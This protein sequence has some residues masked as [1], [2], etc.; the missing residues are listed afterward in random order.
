MKTNKIENFIWI[1][2]LVIGLI[3]LIVGIIICINTFDY[4]DKIETTGVITEITSYRNRDGDTIHNVYVKYEING[5]QYESKL[6]SYSSNFYEGKE[7]KIYY[8][9]DNIGNIGVKSLDLMSLMFPGFGIIFSSIG[10]IS[11]FVQL[12][13]KKLEKLLKESGTRINAYYVETVINTSYSVNNNHPYNIICEW[14]NPMDNKKYIFKSENIWVNPE[15]II[16]ERNITT[17]PVYIDMNNKK[18]YVVDI[19]ELEDNVVDLR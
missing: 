1:S 7:I 15:S 4:T 3:F 17:F 9:K 5:K 12:R 8:E 16:T 6:N 10:G 13:K 2:F 18:K 11:L 19:D 14:N